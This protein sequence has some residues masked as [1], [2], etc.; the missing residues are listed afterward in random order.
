MVKK[1]EDLIS[2]ADDTILWRYMSFSKF[3]SLLQEKALFFCR[4][5]KFADPY[6]FSIPRKEFEH[7]PLAYKKNDEFFQRKHDPIANQEKIDGV[8]SHHKNDKTFTVNNCWNICKPDELTWKLYLTDNE[9]VAI[10]TTKRSLEKSLESATEDIYLS[11]IR[12]IDFEKE[13]W[14]HKEHYP[15]PSYSFLSPIIHKRT[16]FSTEQELRVFHIII[17]RSDEYWKT[18]P[19]TNGLLIKTDVDE[20][21]HKVYFHPTADEFAKRQIRN[22]VTEFGFSFHLHES[23]LPFNIYF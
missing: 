6:E 12:Y 13:G 8:A 2:V 22:T 17:D 9:G 3:R 15:V 14:Y 21:I 23:Q 1:H 4:A 19:N 5:D 16:E 18:Q 11:K 10:Q 20:L 7:R